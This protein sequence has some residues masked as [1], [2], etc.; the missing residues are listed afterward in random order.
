MTRLRARLVAW[1]ES[2]V[3]GDDGGSERAAAPEATRRVRLAVAQSA[4]GA[5]STVVMGGLYAALGS[6]LSALALLILGVGLLLLPYALRRGASVQL[7]GN[8]LTALAFLAIL[9]VA[10]RSG[11][12]T[13]PSVAWN[14]LLPLA[15]YAVCGRRSAMAWTV[16]AAAQIAGLELAAVAGVTFPQDFSGRA[17]AMLRTVADAGVLMA[18][19]ALLLVVDATR[20]AALGAQRAAELALDRQRILEDMHDG[21]GSHLLGLLVQS[22]AGTLQPDDLTR[23]LESCVDDL[24]LIVDSLDPQQASLPMALA[25]LRARVVARCES[26]GIA[27]RWEIDEAPLMRVSPPTSLQILRALQEML[28]NALRHAQAS[29]VEVRVSLHGSDAE[30]SRRLEISVSDDGVGLSPARASG[31]ELKRAP[32]GRGMKS[33]RTRARKLGGVLVVQERHPRGLRVAIELPPPSSRDSVTEP[34]EVW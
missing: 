14:F 26:V 33:L 5:L 19:V 34:V 32:A 7:V 31:T 11:G 6:P 24:R 12:P 20:A 16:L 29:T 3:A 17:L 8:G 1:V 21:V 22:R 4:L 23:S 25:A 10:L 27:L 28:N 2:F 15:I 13:S 18:V 30:P 9:A